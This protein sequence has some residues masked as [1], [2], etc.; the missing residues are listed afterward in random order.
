MKKEKKKKSDF[1]LTWTLNVLMQT[2][3]IYAKMFDMF[4]DVPAHDSHWQAVVWLVSVLIS[5]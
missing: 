2:F 4:N 3:D 5:H 1:N